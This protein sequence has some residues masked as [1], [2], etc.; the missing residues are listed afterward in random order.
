M[1][2]SDSPTSR[3]VVI[4]GYRFFEGSI[5]RYGCTRSSRDYSCCQRWRLQISEKFEYYVFRF[6]GI[7]HR[8]LLFTQLIFIWTCRFLH[9]HHRLFL[10]IRLRTAKRRTSPRG[11]SP[12]AS[13][14]TQHGNKASKPHATFS[15]FLHDNG[16][17]NA[18]TAQLTLLHHP[19]T[20]WQAAKYW[21]IA[22]PDDLAPLP[23]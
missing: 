19:V 2:P 11:L 16:T 20:S 17:G 15:S 7:F 6:A 4:F 21:C 22:A 14:S 18:E 9:L 10:W 13:S 8:V 12:S 3:V 5:H 1:T 23:W